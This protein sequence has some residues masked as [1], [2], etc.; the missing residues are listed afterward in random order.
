MDKTPRSRTMEF[1]YGPRAYTLLK[2]L[3]ATVDT[4]LADSALTSWTIQPNSN[5]ASITIRFRLDTE[6]E[7]WARSMGNIAKYKLVLI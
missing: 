6:A 2:R 4:F 7:I 1:L 5:T 3:G